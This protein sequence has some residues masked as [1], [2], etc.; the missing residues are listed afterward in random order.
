MNSA[1]A[2]DWIC[3]QFYPDMQQNKAKLDQA[4]QKQVPEKISAKIIRP[5]LS[6]DRKIG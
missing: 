4:P 6:Q 5:N 1:A 2:C 3:V